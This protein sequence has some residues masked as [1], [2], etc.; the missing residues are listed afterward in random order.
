MYSDQ[1][2]KTPVKLDVRR[3][4]LVDASKRSAVG[5]AS[6]ESMLNKLGKQA[7]SILQT[8]IREIKTEK[9]KP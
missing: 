9:K 2:Y 8:S 6:F 3:E 1:S 7:E 5:P 4:K